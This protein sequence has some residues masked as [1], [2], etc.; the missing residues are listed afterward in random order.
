MKLFFVTSFKGGT[1]RS[2]AALN[3]A[4]HLYRKG[5]RVLLLD[6]DLF[7][8]SLLNICNMV[9]PRKPSVKSDIDRY[10][11]L[12]GK[13]TISNFLQTGELDPLAIYREDLTGKG[14]R[15]Y[16]KKIRGNGII[17]LYP[18]DVVNVLNDE[19][20]TDEQPIQYS[21]IPSRFHNFLQT[22]QSEA[23][24]VICDL[25]SGVS[26]LTKALLEDSGGHLLNHKPTW[27]VFCRITPQ[28]V[29]GLTRLLD[30]VA[31]PRETPTTSS[32][33]TNEEPRRVKVIETAQ[34][35]ERQQKD[36]DALF[37]AVNHR[38]EAIKVRL[39]RQLNI[40]FAEAL[41]FETALL[42]I[43][44]IIVSGYPYYEEMEKLAV[45]L[46]REKQ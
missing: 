23:D 34:P 39:K 37:S 17:W 29:S 16:D 26:P 7:A 13:L 18:S 46:I 42:L 5:N 30:E 22:I 19:E 41:P 3:L 10:S 6:L 12:K 4:H 35:T 8:P 38:T 44:G 11:T 15:L 25:S 2:V 36:I 24:F 43:E 40:Q 31:T 27:L 32:T 28:Q 45:K 14:R 1:G 21:Q 33:A 9:N 20:V